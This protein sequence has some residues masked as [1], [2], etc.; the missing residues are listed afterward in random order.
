[1]RIVIRTTVMVVMQ[2]EQ[3]LGLKRSWRKYESYPDIVAT[4]TMAE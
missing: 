1:M 2:G 4:V 3:V